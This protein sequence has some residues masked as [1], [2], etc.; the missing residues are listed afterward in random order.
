MEL[1]NFG[2]AARTLVLN[3]SHSNPIKRGRSLWDFGPR[4]NNLVTFNWQSS[5]ELS[6]TDTESLSASWLPPSFRLYMTTLFF[7]RSL[8]AI[9]SI[10]LKAGSIDV[11]MGFP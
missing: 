4:Q 5:I 3:S 11:V 2:A 6:K 10:A 1:L 8:S 7:L 9:S